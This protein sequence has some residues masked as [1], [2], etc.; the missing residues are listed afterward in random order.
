MSEINGDIITSNN[1][2]IAVIAEFRSVENTL[3]GWL[4]DTPLSNAI[5]FNQT[6]S[7]HII[8]HF[9]SPYDSL[10]PSR[11]SLL[12]GSPFT[13]AISEA[14]LSLQESGTLQQLRRRWWKEK[15]GGGRCQSD[16]SQGSS[17]ANA[18]GVH[19]VGGVFVVLLAGMGL[20][21]VVA[22]CEFVWKSRKLATEEHGSVWTE[23]SKEF[24]SA[25]SCD[26]A[27]PPPKGKPVRTSTP[28]EDKAASFHSTN[29]YDSTYTASQYS[30]FT[31][32]DPIS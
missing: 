11:Y 1:L 29:I 24:K 27:A 23:M 2:E 21:S 12:T 17:K 6:S 9:I 15:K 31:C 8:L 28:E 5:V 32:K 22:V 13:N 3:M 25:L 10:P 16:E 18:L 19:N 30:T 26:T 4:P 7:L 14:I 20:A